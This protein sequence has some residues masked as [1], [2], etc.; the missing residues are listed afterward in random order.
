MTSHPTSRHRPRHATGRRRDARRTAPRPRPRLAAYPRDPRRRAARRRRRPRRARRRARRDRQE[1][2]GLAEARLRGELK[3]TARAAAP[4]RARRRGRR[5][6]RRAHRRRRP[7]VRRSGPAPTCAATL[8]PLG[9]VL[10]LRGEQLPVR[11]LRRRRRHR[12]ALAAGCPV[13]VKAHPG[14]PG[15]SERTAALVAGALAAAGLPDGHAS[16]LV[17]GQ[18]AGVALLEHPAV[19]AGRVHR[20]RAA[21]APR[22]TSPPRDPTRS[23]STASSGAQPGAGHR[24]R[25]RRARGRHRRRLH[26]H[27]HRRRHER[28]STADA[29]HHFHRSR[30][31]HDRLVE[32]RE[33]PAE[34]M[35]LLGP[36]APDEHG[37]RHP[38][39]PRRP[40]L[41]APDAREEHAQRGVERLITRPAATSIVRVLV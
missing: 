11:V 17:D 33:E 9:P 12:G 14:H 3:R 8:V 2:T 19:A 16:Q 22:S 28:R 21:A 30:P 40:E 36:D 23:R 37:V 13:V 10:E 1:E 27:R 26:E 20:S 4:V 41:E 24:G 5:L 18:E 38:A 35:R 25:R 31:V 32:A 34:W 6:P 15:L 29:T 7:R 39:Q